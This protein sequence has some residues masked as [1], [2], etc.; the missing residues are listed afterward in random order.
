[1][2][3]FW[4]HKDFPNFKFKTDDFISQFQE[5]ASELGEVNGLFLNQD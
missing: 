5:F 2:D 4:Q 1:M 3:Y